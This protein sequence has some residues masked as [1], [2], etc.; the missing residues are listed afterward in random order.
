MINILPIITSNSKQA[1][2]DYCIYDAGVTCNSC[3]RFKNTNL[4]RT[5]LDEDNMKTIIEINIYKDE[6]NP[7]HSYHEFIDNA[8]MKIPDESEIFVIEPHEGVVYEETE[9]YPSSYYL[10]KI[11]ELIKNIAKQLNKF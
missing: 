8:M 11:R 7:A 10:I 5:I 9:L 1:C 2:P 3:E 6:G 4:M